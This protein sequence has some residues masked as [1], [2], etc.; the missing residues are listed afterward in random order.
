VYIWNKVTLKQLFWIDLPLVRC[1]F[2]TVDV[3]AKAVLLVAFRSIAIQLRL[4]ATDAF[5]SRPLKKLD[6][7]V[8]TS[9]RKVHAP[10]SHHR[11]SRLLQAQ[12][13][14]TMPTTHE[15]I[16]AM[17]EANRL[18]ME[19]LHDRVRFHCSRPRKLP[20]HAWAGHPYR[21][22]AVT[23]TLLVDDGT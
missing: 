4:S 21:R 11:V 7:S 6:G 15:A 23:G 12:S 22:A 1:S 16:D 17:L 3:P 9:Y 18:Q 14:R 8:T 20:T 13:R 2:R 5:T 10:G 19:A